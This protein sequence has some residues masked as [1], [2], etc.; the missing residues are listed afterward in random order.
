MATWRRHG[1]WRA[2]WL[3]LP[4]AAAAAAWAVTQQFKAPIGWRVAFSALAVVVP[5]VVVELRER[6][7]KDDDKVKV[8]RAHLHQYSRRRGVPTVGSIRDLRSFGV[9]TARRGQSAGVGPY[10]D[11]DVDDRLDE[12]LARDSF[13]LVIGDAKAGKSRVAAEAVRRNFR[14]RQFIFPIGAESLPAILDAEIDLDNSVVWLD[15]LDRYLD[16]GGLA[17]LLDVLD[18]SDAPRHCAVV[19]TIRAQAFGR[20]IPH[21]GVESPAWPTLSRAER[22]RLERLLSDAERE[23]AATVVSDPQV[24][25]ALDR[26][27]LAE[28]L[29]AGP[30]LIERLEDGMLAKPVGALVVLIT[31][32]WF[33]TGSRRALTAETLADL[34]PGYAATLGVEL[35]STGEIQDAVTWARQPIYAASA[36]MSGDARGYRVFDYVLDYVQ[37][38]S[39]ASPVQNA[40]WEAALAAHP[41]VDEVLQI[42][43]TANAQGR[44]DIALVA[45]EQAVNNAT[46]V[47]APIAAYNYASALRRAGRVTEASVYFRRAA[48]AGHVEAAYA[49]GELAEADGELGD[50]E[51]Y[52]TQAAEQGHHDAAF[53]LGTLLRGRDAGAALRWFRRAADAGHVEAAYSAGQLS[54][55]SD[56]PSEAER[57]FGQAAERNHLDAAFALGTLLRGRDVTAALSWFRRA[58]DAGHV[59]AAHAAGHL[60]RARGESHEAERY[61]RLASSLASAEPGSLVPES[62]RAVLR[63]GARDLPLDVVE[64]VRALATTMT[65]RTDGELR[66]LSHVYRR[67]LGRGE[68]VTDLM[69]EAFAAYAEATQRLRRIEVSDGQLTGGAALH[70]GRVVEMQPGQGRAQAVGLA[71]YL[72]ALGGDG[73]H[74]MS[75]DDAAA[76]ADDENIGAVH[77]FLGLRAGLMIPGQRATARRAIYDGDIVYGGLSEFAFDYIRDGLAWSTDELTQRG[78]HLAI[79][80]D[81]D[82]ALLD[83]LRESYSITGDFNQDNRWYAEFARIVARMRL[84]VHYTCDEDSRRVTPLDAG[85]DLVEDQLGIDRLYAV[86]NGEVLHQFTLAIKAQ[87]LY[88]RGRDYQVQD[89]KIVIIDP[90]TGAVQTT[91]RYLDGIRQ[92]LEAKEG[93]PVSRAT[94][95]R[96]TIGW[97]PFVRRYRRLA[98]IAGSATIEAEAFRTFYDMS[99]TEVPPDQPVIREDLLDYLYMSDRA[100]WEGAADIISERHDTGQPVLVEVTDNAEAEWLRRR[101]RERTVP[102]RLLTTENRDEERA[103][104][105]AAAS[106]GAVTIAVNIARTRVDIPLGGPEGSD[107]AEVRRLG[108]LFVLGTRRHM[109]RRLDERLRDLS[110]RRGE[111]GTSQFLNAKADAL[112][113]GMPWF[114]PDAVYG[115]GPIATRMLT[116]AI[117][118]RQRMARAVDLDQQRRLQKWDAVLEDHRRQLRDL[119]DQALLGDGVAQLTLG[120]LD[121]TL[122]AY[123]QKSFASGAA[124]QPELLAAVRQLFAVDAA[125]IASRHDRAGLREA[126]GRVGRLAWQR[127]EEEL[128]AEAWFE[129]QRQVLWNVIDRQWREH[130]AVLDDLWDTALLERVAGRESLIVYRERAERAFEEMIGRVKEETVGFLFNLEVD[131]QGY[132]EEQPAIVAGPAAEDAD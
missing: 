68:S 49:A 82:V 107:A 12:L 128:G 10:V 80:H 67:R 86:E 108:G 29:A 43:L 64:S 41:D 18:G 85:I 91:Q 32:D 106:K 28:Y 79:L 44:I 104:L 118:A 21:E 37:T 20:H 70:S 130:I 95:T 42:G 88:R 61:L 3:L 78:L 19:A 122:D 111:P 8:F 99:V 89:G 39:K 16:K 117:A 59:Q 40:T 58:A 97:M 87:A 119:R 110:G 26:Y 92:A 23:R 9:G 102:C 132:A 116:R 129:L 55:A 48:D 101:L 126:L 112:F 56:D 77:R 75:L 24:L 100:R 63:R 57:Y 74:V 72:E 124:D 113:E 105:S 125:D 15:E 13:V 5:L 33:R 31:V 6:F 46:R 109:S 115:D 62:T 114:L 52:L 53:A 11:R 45:F 71:T 30:D 120:Y 27:G 1:G 17:R 69:P 47:S 93:L 96:A 35:P 25:N 4:A 60:L 65:T 83:N 94:E 34:L 73:V 36:L 51:R 54:E 90:Q 38:Q 131:V 103:M 22:V 76:A 7:K 2:L 127:R 50:A 81:A 121:Q 14:H 123:V 98:A 66:Q 84:D